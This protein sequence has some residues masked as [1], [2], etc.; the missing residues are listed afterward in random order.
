MQKRWVVKE[1]GN[2]EKVQHL[3]EKL[4]VDE[5]LANLLVQRGIDS[6]EEAK[7]FFRP[8]L[9]DLHDPLL[10][11]DMDKAL[12]RLDQALNSNEKILI[13]G[14]YDV[15]G[16]TAVSLVY[17]FLSELHEELDYY[18]PD[19]YLEGY[20]VSLQGID[21]AEEEG[22]SLIIA[23]DCGIKANAQVEYA[24]KKGIEFI[25]CDHH[26]PGAHLPNAQAVL[27][28]KREDC[29]YPYDE[30][31]GCGIGFKLMQA[32][33]EKRGLPFNKLE[34]LLDLLV[35]SIAS[36]IV[37]ITGEN[38]VLAYYGL[39]RLNSEPRQ[40][41]Q[42]LIGNSKKKDKFSITDIVFQLGP[43]I[44]AAGRIGSGRNAVQ[45]LL[46]EDAEMA[47]GVGQKIE[48]HNQERKDLDREICEQ[49]LELLEEKPEWMGRK[50][51]VL[52]KDDWHKGVIGI[53]ASRVIEKHYRPTI[54]LTKSN[55]TV[56]GSARS[57]KEFDIYTALEQCSDLLEQFGG[58]KY[59]AGLTLKEENIHAF[60][61]RFEEVV[62]ASISEEQLVPKVTIDCSL[63]LHE[64]TPKFYR[65]LKQ[66]GPFGPGNMRPVFISEQVTDTGWGRIVGESHLKLNVRQSNGN[67][68]K[69]PV[70][71]FGQ[72]EHGD[73]VLNSQP[74]DLAYTIE[75]NEWNGKREL[76]LSAKD[77]RY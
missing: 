6:F 41:I 37:P 22:C 30:L 49:A 42:T 50:S 12:E 62:A 34:S 52:Y 4:G 73:S 43:R 25:I 13:Y 31:S 77:L 1:P 66:L 48:M 8:Q 69:F 51:C 72:G 26:K 11:K 74:F 70:I 63:D 47:Q 68:T 45:L 46:A 5:V 7:H 3:A 36:D 21:Y 58:H 20:G 35:I 75:E 10:M 44:N 23:L 15:D 61:E 27:D 14:D 9:T 40:G 18:I 39:Q 54:I 55:G 29:E 76:Q 56:T 19:R 24:A 28:P 53:V 59:A 32:L 38:R 71:A 64:I 16:T 67:G 57:V 60:R 33:A 2:A 17:H 65:V